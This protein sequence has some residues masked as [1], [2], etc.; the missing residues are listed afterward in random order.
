MNEQKKKTKKNVSNLKKGSNVLDVEKIISESNKLR[1][2]FRDQFAEEMYKIQE[3]THTKGKYEIAIKYTTKWAK[4]MQYLNKEE[5][6]EIKDIAVL[7]A[8][9]AGSDEVSPS[10]CRYAS[11]LLMDFW[12]Y[13]DEI[14][15][16]FF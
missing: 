1:L 7:A 12:K 10:V 8:K 15:H 5:N 3:E 9:I 11:Y 6:E 4:I 2:E 13:G 14:K 16:I